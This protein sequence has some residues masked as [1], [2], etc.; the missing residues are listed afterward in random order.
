[1]KQDIATTVLAHLVEA[2]PQTFVLEKY[3]PHRPLKIGIAVD[4]LTCCPEFSRYTLGRALGV[5]T[6]RLMYLEAMVAGA[7]RVDLDSNPAGEVTADEAEH[8]VVKLAGIMAAR[9][10]R[11]AAAVAAKVAERKT[12]PVPPAPAPSPAAKVLPMKATPVLRLPAF[13]TAAR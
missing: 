5:Y 4:L 10:A 8:A 1:M 13:R 2:F 9:R 11:R 3:R 6:A 7:T 12:T